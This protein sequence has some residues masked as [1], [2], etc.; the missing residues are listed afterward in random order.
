MR[1]SG[2]ACA[3]MDILWIS[4]QGEN[5]GKRGDLKKKS[6]LKSFSWL[7][8]QLKAVTASLS[9]GVHSCLHTLWSVTVF[10][11]QK[12][13]L[14][15]SC[16]F[17]HK[18]VLICTMPD[19]VQLTGL[20]RS[21]TPLTNIV[22]MLS[23]GANK[24]SC[25]SFALI[26]TVMQFC[27]PAVAWSYKDLSVLVEWW[28]QRWHLYLIVFV[29]IPSPWQQF[30]IDCC[31]HAECNTPDCTVLP[32]TGVLRTNVDVFVH[33]KYNDS[34]TKGLPCNLKTFSMGAKNP[35]RSG[36][37]KLSCLPWPG[38]SIHLE[39]LAKG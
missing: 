35:T 2:K 28:L 38:L 10:P 7:L 33:K 3:D 5:K 24:A 16:E 9:L 29:E 14:Y 8:S 12:S 26:D 13:I 27:P 32:W 20:I 30:E 6:L 17:L 21:I 11:L 39:L 23:F 31:N 19:E 25:L 34:Y 15:F 36:F 4:I 1:G 37:K 18:R 22:C